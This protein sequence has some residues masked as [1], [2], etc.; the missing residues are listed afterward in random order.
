MGA[1]HGVRLFDALIVMID[2]SSC[3]V[4]STGTDRFFDVDDD[5]DDLHAKRTRTLSI[6]FGVR[7]IDGHRYFRLRFI[8]SITFF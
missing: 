3:I 7:A 4:G 2:V 8:R 1:L 5:D 6:V